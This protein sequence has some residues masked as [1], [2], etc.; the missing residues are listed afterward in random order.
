M[1]A[2]P[3]GFYTSYRKWNRAKM[4]GIGPGLRC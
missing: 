1:T 2:N 4:L 3:T